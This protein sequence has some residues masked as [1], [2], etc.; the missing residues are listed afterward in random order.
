VCL[1]NLPSALLLTYF[2]ALWLAI[3]IAWTRRAKIILPVV[4]GGALG[5]LLSGIYLLPAVLELRFIVVPENARSHFESNFLFQGS[6]S[7]MRPGLRSVFDRMGL[8][9][10]LAAAVALLVLL[11]GRRARP[12]AADESAWVRLLAT[13]AG[14]SLF[15]ATPL[16]SPGWK[17]LPVL[18]E[19]NLPWR[20]LEPLGAAAAA[21]SAAAAVSL[22]RRRD[23]PRLSRVAGLVVL[24]ALFVL[25]GV[26]SDS[27][28]AMNG[29]FPAAL[30]RASIERFARKEGYFL[31][32]GARRAADLVEMP[33]LACDRPCRVRPQE[34]SPA[35]RR[36][37]VDAPGG[38]HLALTTYF[39]PGWSAR[40]E[41]SSSARLPVAAE[42]GTGRLLVAVPPGSHKIAIV[43]D[44]TPARTLGAVAS[45]LGVAIWL[46]LRFAPERRA[47]TG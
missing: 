15:F 8:F 5:A 26:L 29:S 44:G 38:T 34:W 45:A 17:L 43:F 16:S 11:S 36:L 12:P 14:V 1:V 40:L 25:C 30:A 27:V 41:D 2:V 21:L 28:S 31:P 4:V 23:V 35:R 39:F 9:P 42:P 47:A 13:A 10:A 3:E 22:S 24:G 32:K 20:L 6:A 33:N 46:F 19:V 7:W 18:H 37:T